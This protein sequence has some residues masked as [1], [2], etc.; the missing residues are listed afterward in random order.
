MAQGKTTLGNEN[1]LVTRTD[2]NTRRSGAYGDRDGQGVFKE[3]VG[4]RRNHSIEQRVFIE[5]GDRRSG[6]GLRPKASGSV[7]RPTYLF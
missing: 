6:A 2:E 7:A 5:V 3:H 1:T 4:P